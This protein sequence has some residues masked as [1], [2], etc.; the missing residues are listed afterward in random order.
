[1]NV[2]LTKDGIFL[3]KTR[4]IE[5]VTKGMTFDG[6]TARLKE[7]ALHIKEIEILDL[8]ENRQ[9]SIDFCDERDGNTHAVLV[10]DYRVTEIC[11]SGCWTVKKSMK[12]TAGKVFETLAQYRD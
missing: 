10:N 6:F 1:M 8:D 5:K 12:T 7:A 2:Y 4:A 9:F 11:G 3:N